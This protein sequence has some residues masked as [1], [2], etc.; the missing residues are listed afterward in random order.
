MDTSFV[1]TLFNGLAEAAAKANPKTSDDY[2]GKDD[3]LYCGKCGTPKQCI[4]KISGNAIKVPCMCKCA[5][6]D[7]KRSEEEERKRQRQYRIE[8]AQEK[9]FADRSLSK[10]KFEHDDS[11]YSQMS[12]IARNY[13]KH[14]QEMS[15]E[16][17]GLVFF[18]KLGTGKTFYAACIANQ[19]IREGYKVLVTSFP[20]LS[21]N[22]MERMDGRQ[23][24]LDSLD[25]YDLI[26]I[27]DFSVE[28]S[29]EYMMETVYTVVDARYKSGKPLIVTT[30]LTR[31]Q[32][33]DTNSD[34]RRARI[35][36]RLYEMCFFVESEGKDRRIRQMREDYGRLGEML[37]L[38]LKTKREE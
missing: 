36:S 32:I 3:L 9:G 35:I 5:E 27:D 15:K 23:E 37:G 1:T 28:R 26:V 17:K 21:N 18:G 29:T 6:E 19:L 34:I 24:Y 13:V 20:R 16:G 22:L 33:S 12:T 7:Y 14:F 25:D 11:P 38:P 4:V 30:N 8:Q 2:T 10:C 31:E